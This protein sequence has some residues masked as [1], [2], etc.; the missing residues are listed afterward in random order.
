[1]FLLAVLVLIFTGSQ[2]VLGLEYHIIDL[3]TLGG[4][5]SK[6]FGINEYDQIVGGAETASGQSHAFIYEEGVMTDIGTLGG[7]TSEAW[8]LNENG[9]IVG[10]STNGAGRN[11]AFLY[12]DGVMYDLGTLGGNESKASGINNG[13]LIVGSSKISSGYWRAMVYE[14]G[15]MSQ[16]PKF[17]G[18]ESWASAINSN[19]QIV[20]GCNV[21]G[22]SPWHACLWEGGIIQD[23]GTLPGTPKSNAA[24]INDEGQ[25]V[26]VS[27]DYPSLPSYGFIYEDGVMS[28]IGSLGHSPD[29][30]RARAI[31]NNGQIVG[32]SRTTDGYLHA[33]VYEDGIMTD[34]GTLGGNTSEARSI[35]EAGL[36]VGYAETTEGDIHAVLWTPFVVNVAVDIKPRS[37]PN[38]LN[39]KSRGVLPVAVLGSEDFDVN[40]VDIASI[41]LAGVGPI[42]SSYED[43]AA[44]VSDANDCNCTTAG[45]DGYTD[46]TLKFETYKI[47][48]AIGEVTDGEVLPL[49]IAGVLLDE[50][51]IEG[52]DCIV[53]RGSHKPFNKADITKDGVVDILDFAIIAESWLQ[54]S[55]VDD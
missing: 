53:I 13:G 22:G 4:G 39:V 2:S 15:A 24:G 7:N 19:G 21:S 14:G 41:C 9:Q 54:S 46:L 32:R 27:N 18:T 44:P 23:L 31:N 42:R 29:D 16:L 5:E 36:I 35:N 52:A 30:T 8:G 55:I 10:N 1:L 28:G 43:V 48:N 26:G 37:C 25:I 47:V 33:F 11:R 20:G 17:A 45:P 51:H 49:T 40:T 3:G 12:E 34:L 38:P 50:T 6:A